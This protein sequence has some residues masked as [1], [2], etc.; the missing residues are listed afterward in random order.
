M[1]ENKDSLRSSETKALDVIVGTLGFIVGSM[2]GLWV[3]IELVKI[4][5]KVEPIILYPI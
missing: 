4:Q 1:E 2:L 3:L 5:S